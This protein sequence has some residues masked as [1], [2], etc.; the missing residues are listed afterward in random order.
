MKKKIIT[1]IVFSIVALLYFTRDI[2]TAIGDSPTPGLYDVTGA[3]ISD[4]NDGKYQCTTYFYG[5]AIG[6]NLQPMQK[7]DC[8]K[9]G[10]K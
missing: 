2:N 5:N 10:G 7:I 8:R 4:G 6:K 3:S 1:I 9:R